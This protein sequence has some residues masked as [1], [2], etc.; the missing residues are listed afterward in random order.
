MYQRQVTSNSNQNA[1]R[2]LH[3]HSRL[4]HIRNCGSKLAKVAFTK[5][6]V[7]RGKLTSKLHCTTN[8]FIA[9]IDAA[10]DHDELKLHLLQNL[11]TLNL[12]FFR[13][14]A[15]A[16][17][18]LSLYKMLTVCEGRSGGRR[19]RKS[20]QLVHHKSF[21]RRRKGFTPAPMTC[22]RRDIDA[23]PAKHAGACTNWSHCP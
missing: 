19:K 21:Y 20:F 14:T 8:C 1:S 15:G 17:K 16:D 18:T 23:G 11:A 12:N 3:Q 6:H 7:H 2:M 5:D 10:D 4:L 13:L 22:L 9:D